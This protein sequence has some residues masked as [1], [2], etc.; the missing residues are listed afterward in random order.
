MGCPAEQAPEGGHP[1]PLICR[2]RQRF[3]RGH[4]KKGKEETKREQGQGF[5][6]RC[7]DSFL[8]LG[9]SWFGRSLVS[10]NF[11]KIKTLLIRQNNLQATLNLC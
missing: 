10:N 2:G 4:L 9:S 1:I 3:V 11:G 8:L 6:D 7:M 5:L